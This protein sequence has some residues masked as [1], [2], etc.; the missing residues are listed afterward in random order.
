MGD[1]QDNRFYKITNDSSLT[2]DQKKKFVAQELV[3][4]DPAVATEY[5]EY[6]THLN[7]E[8]QRISDELAA[9]VDDNAF[10]ELR[11]SSTN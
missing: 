1:I 4:S 6:K 10:K 8:R 3:K 5:L 9:S 11:A 7:D 2:T